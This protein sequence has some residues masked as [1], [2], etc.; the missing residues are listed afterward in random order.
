MII[1]PWDRKG[2]PGNSFQRDFLHWHPE[3][4]AGWGTLLPEQGEA[5]TA[6]GF[7]SWKEMGS[8]DQNWAQEVLSWLFVPLVKGRGADAAQHF[9]GSLPQSCV[10]CISQL[11]QG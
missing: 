10:G 2:V 3:P 8:Q 11:L 7:L 6:S 9:Q 4:G 5:V 1:V